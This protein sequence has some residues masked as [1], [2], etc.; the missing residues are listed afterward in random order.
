V[1]ATD[2]ARCGCCAGV[3]ALTPVDELNPPGQT[4]L[5][6]R[7]GTQARFMETQLARLSTEPAL[8]SL[9][10]RDT[11]D[12][13]LALLDAWSSVLDVLSFYQERI[14]NEGYL[15]TATERRSVL[16]LARS[17][18]YE[19]RPGVAASTFLSFTLE[20]APG[21]PLAARI[22]AG[23]K[24]QSVPAQDEKPQV[25]E[26]LA[27][28]QAR[29][30]WNAIEVLNQEAVP[31][32]WGGNT[33]YLQGQSTRL[34]P[35]DALLVVGDERRLK[36][37]NENWDF[38]RV[39][40]V[41]V[42]PPAQPSADPL[43]G[44][45]VVTLDRPLGSVTPYTEPA[46]VAPRCYALRTK[47]ALFGQAAADWRAMPRS[48]RAAFLGLD[49][50]E[51]PRIDIKSQP[52]WP[53]FTV[54][55]VADGTS[56]TILLD[57][58][59]PKIGRGSWIVLSIP[60]YDEV[61]EVTDAREDGRAAFG[62]AGKSSRLALSGENLAE[63]FDTHLR[64]TALYGESVELGWATRPRSGFVEG[65][66]VTLASLQAEL[67]A[68][69]W[70]AFSGHVLADVAD[71]RLLRRRLRAGDHLAA[72]EL[73]KDDASASVTFTN[74]ERFAAV[75]QRVSEVVQ[76]ART[77]PVDGR[78]QL[79]LA[80]D[81]LHAYLPL[82]LRINA[83]V[84]PASHGDSKQMKIQPEVLGS[85]NGSAA[86]QRFTLR[87]KPLTYVSATT[88][89]GTEATLDLRVDGV[90]WRE[91][92]RLTD[93][94]PNDKAYLVRRADDGTVTV[95]FGDGVHG[96]RLPSGQ[97]N[98]EARYRV[99]IGREANLRAGQISMLLERALGVKDVVNPVPATGGADPEVLADARRNAPL[100]VLALERIVSL[101]DF[102]DYA[103]AFAGVGKAQA[104]WLWDGERRL[105][106]LTVVGLAGADI[107]KG[108][109]LY[110]NLVASIDGVRPAH[111]ALR[112]EPGTMLRFGFTAKLRIDPDRESRVVLEAVR[113]ALAEAFGFLQRGYGQSLS[114][115]EVTS[116]IQRVAGIQ[117]VDLDVLRLHPGG[118]AAGPD[119]RLRVRGARWQ[120]T[121]ILPAQ[122]LLIDP[123][124]VVLTELST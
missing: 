96:R 43:A 78:T 99:G 67:P 115:S 113:A 27:A 70:L 103:A 85:G 53:Q 79:T 110:R 45:T 64:D 26:T 51:D 48:L 54:T 50:L 83:N 31:P 109:A 69:R 20:T 102:E 120:G 16:E 104:V 14:A 80:S 98:L 62:L 15:R 73:G 2:D 4:A 88:P 108:S 52:D 105:V 56:N 32:H 42:V 21:A 17:I 100:T 36:P 91:A 18:G 63:R 41:Q 23:T 55:D 90:R 61:Y 74:G 76:L 112:V 11:S 95:G 119:G 44:T 33:L 71:N 30:A 68:E 94:G 66:L 8:Q 7:V 101:R 9:T 19:L 72:V 82:T 28:L 114:G 47:A 49:D 124:D 123:A 12:P 121:Q 122:L 39:A 87:Q 1:S 75:L 116:V 3:I 86:F 89:S 5:H 59:Y 6:Y 117:R 46:A 107:D 77:D 29:A 65:H 118:S 84:A 37:G 60:G 97:M 93:L 40:R 22:D 57:A 25:F 81:L 24:T 13:A 35:G 111:Q 10:T 92:A 34:S 106:H 38:R 58:S